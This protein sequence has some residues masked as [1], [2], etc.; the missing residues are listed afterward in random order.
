MF[1]V[2]LALLAAGA[3]GLSAVLVRMGLRDLS[4]PTGTLISLASGL[5][6]MGS[7]TAAFERQEL[8]ELSWRAFLLF[9]LVGILS[10]PMGRFFNYM[11]MSRIGVARSTPLLASAPLWAVMIAVLFTGEELRPA[12]V[13]GISLILGGVY[14]TLS[15]RPT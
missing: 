2:V 5:V 12:T 6:L 15:S 4:T 9:G 8:A 3:W 14:L 7:L 1:A 10:F 11:A 13:A